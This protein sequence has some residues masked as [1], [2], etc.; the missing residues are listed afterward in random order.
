MSKFK[1]VVNDISDGPERGSVIIDK[2]WPD[3]VLIIF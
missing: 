1:L 3:G 2:D